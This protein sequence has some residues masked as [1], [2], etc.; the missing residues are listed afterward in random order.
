MTETDF[1]R[2]NKYISESGI[3]SRREADA[4]IE[5]KN[6][7]VNGKVAELGQRVGPMDVV[8]VNGIVVEPRAKEDEIYILFNKP[9]GI[10]STTDPADKDN[11]IKYI[12]YGERIFPVGRLDKDSQGLIIL[13]SN[14]DIVNKILRAGNQHEKEY[15]VTVDKPI[16][17]HFIQ[18]MSSGVPIL[19]VNTR[20]CKIHAESKF[21]FR[22]TLTQGMNRQIRRMCEY[23]GYD[24][25]KL[26]RVRI[27]NLNVKGIPLGDYREMRP[28]ELAELQEMIKD[29][30]ATID[31][32][33]MT[34]IP[35]LREA[36]KS[37]HIARSLQGRT[38]PSDTPIKS[39]RHKKVSPRANPKSAENRKS[40]NKRGELKGR[41]SGS[42]RPGGKTVGRSGASNKG[43]KGGRRK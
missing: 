24:V 6:V 17:E 7:L 35:E 12:K 42:S 39:E 9:V 8:K 31:P 38:A 33:K 3:C 5:S 27:M 30:E 40:A 2:L 19:G 29:S 25:L 36:E 43:R 32:H 20:K 21:V 16:T 22:I 4:F 28:Q 41:R 13:T 37:M 10:T 14:G 1:I 34:K 11:I 18:S 26:E 23:F 15:V